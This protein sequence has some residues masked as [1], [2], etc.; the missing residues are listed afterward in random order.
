MSDSLDILLRIFAFGVVSIFCGLSY[1]IYLPFK[2]RLR[3]SGKLTDRLSSKINWT[4]VLVPFLVVVIL[5]FLKDLRKSSKDRLENIT[6]IKLPADYKVL[7]DDFEDLGTGYHLLYDIQLD[8]RQVL[9]LIDSIKIK[10]QLNDRDIL[11]DSWSRTPRGFAFSSIDRGISFHIEFDT[12]RKTI[13]YNEQ[14]GVME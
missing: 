8:G 7:R 1:L 14:K 5:Y 6:K 10:G 13:N 4:F 2:N 11:K 3:K 12:L 9:S